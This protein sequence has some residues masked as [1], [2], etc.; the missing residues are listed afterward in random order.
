MLILSR[1]FILLVLL[2]MPTLVSASVSDSLKSLIGGGDSGSKDSGNMT[3]S[4]FE[5]M[6]MQIREKAIQQTRPPTVS[7]PTAP[8]IGFG[9]YPWHR[10]IMTT[11]FWI[12][13]RPTARNPVPNNRSAWDANWA[14]NYGGYDNPDQRWRRNF[15]PIGFTPRQNPFYVALPYCDVTHGNTKPEAG[16]VIPWFRDCFVRQ[17][18]SVLKGRWIAIHHAGRTCFAQWEDCG[19]FRTDHWQY[20]F[21]NGSVMPRPN[22]NRGAGLDISPAVRDY[23]RMEKNDITDWKFV[24][25]ASVPDGPWKYYGDNNTFAL[26]RKGA[27]LYQQD[28]NNAKRSPSMN[29]YT[30]PSTSALPLGGSPVGVRATPPFAN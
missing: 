7:I 2:M 19:P 17:G 18:K 13:E 24:D 3:P 5:R 4:D 23:L 21:G 29:S 16:R 30:R 27:N 12:G 26:L 22:L 20:V 25:S 1:W 10:N 6:A 28:R 8:V 14:R 9:K 11:I 15:I